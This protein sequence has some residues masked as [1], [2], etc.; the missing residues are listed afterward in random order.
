MQLKLWQPFFSPRRKF[1]NAVEFSVAIF[2]LYS[3]I[4]YFD[5]R[6]LNSIISIQKWLF[7][8]SFTAISI[9]PRLIVSGL[10]ASL[11]I[12]FSIRVFF[13]GH[14]RLTIQQGKRV[15]H[16]LFHST[17]SIRSRTFRHLLRLCMWDDYHIFYIFYCIASIY[18]TASRWDLPPY[19]I[20]IWLIDNM[21]LIFVC[22]LDD[23]LLC[24]CYN[25]LTRKPVYS[26]SH[27]LSP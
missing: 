25:N 6:H 24:F 5:L 27:R 20:T 17:T 15:D 12:Y 7:I 16:L 9:C 1:D 10:R 11:V 14:W 4:I 19:R 26:N 22:L 13:H 18:Q 2:F 3:N 8:V 23:L 21:I